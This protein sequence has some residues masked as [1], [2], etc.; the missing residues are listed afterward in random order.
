MRNRLQKMA[1]KISE[2]IFLALEYVAAAR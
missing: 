1:E 2:V